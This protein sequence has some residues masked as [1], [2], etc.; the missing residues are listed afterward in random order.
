MAKKSTNKKYN[1]VTKTLTLPDGTRKYVYGKNKAEAEAKLAELKAQVSGGVDINDDT[2]FGELAKLWLEKYKAPYVR[3]SS[4]Y[5]IRSLLNARVMGRFAT[6]PVKAIAPLMVQDLVADMVNSGYR[7]TG[8]VLSYL[9]EIFNLAVDLGCIAK[10]PIPS[11]LK[12]P[13]RPPRKEK[14]ILSAEIEDMLLRTLRPLTPDRMFF[15]LGRQNGLRRGEIC[16][17]NWDSIDLDAETLRV[18]RNLVVGK[19]GKTRIVEYTKTAQGLRTVPIP[20]QLKAELELWLSWYGTNGNARSTKTGGFLF[21]SNVGTPYTEKTI[22]MLWERVRRAV[23]TVDPD[24]AAEFTP[25]T[26]RHTFIT[27]LFEAGLDVKEI[28]ALAGHQDVATT[29]G[30]YTHYDRVSRQTETFAKVRNA[31]SGDEEKA[32]AGIIQFQNVVNV[33]N[34]NQAAEG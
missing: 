27:R 23:R 13:A 15:L 14:E 34:R 24:F 3:E 11:T 25:H 1:Y 7:S 4:L 17:M 28:Q 19:S 16:A 2:T 22:A 20:R 32:S 31:V 29:L 12:A 26:L 21:T 10:S 18:H 30:T 9:R 8:A 5:T 33:V 6:I